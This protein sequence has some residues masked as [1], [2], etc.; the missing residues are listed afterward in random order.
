MLLYLV[1][2]DFWLGKLAFF[3]DIH[4]HLFMV[5][6][7]KILAIMIPR[8]LLDKPLRKWLFILACTFIFALF[9][10][11][12]FLAWWVFLN[13]NG[14]GF[15]RFGFGSFFYWF[16]FVLLISKVLS[17]NSIFGWIK[18]HH[19]TVILLNFYIVFDIFDFYFWHDLWP[20]TRKL[21][22]IDLI[23]LNFDIICAVLDQHSLFPSFKNQL[24]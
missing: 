21:C 10:V 15:N 4:W 18:N 7:V 23:C 11:W 24:Y 2:I 6:L 3:S 19:V 16:S 20:E 22:I 12:S 9:L 8:N 1:V 14:F 17:L 13:D 5:K